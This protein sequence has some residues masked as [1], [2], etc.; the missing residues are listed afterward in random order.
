MKMSYSEEKK[1]NLN[2][3]TGIV[4]FF[5]PFWEILM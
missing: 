3:K 2:L 5:V 1:K 4:K